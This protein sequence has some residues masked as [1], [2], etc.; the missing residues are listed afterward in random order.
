MAGASGFIGGAVVRELLAQ[1]WRVRGLYRDSDK[2]SAAIA[3]AGEGLEAC[4]GDGLR[5]GVADRLT[6]GAHA[7]VNCVG[8]LRESRPEATYRRVHV[9]LTEALIGASERAGVDQ[10]VQIS[11]LGVGPAATTEYGISKY[12]AEQIVR[13]SSIDWTILRPSL[14][15]GPDAE[16]MRMI[17]GWTLGRESPR[18]FL[19]YFCR[20]DVPKG[21][22]PRPPKPD[23]AL[24]APV[25]VGDVAR[26]VA[27]ALAH[28]AA[29]GEVYPLCGP[30]V[31]E[32]P[33]L[34][35][36]VRDAIP[37][38][39]KKPIVP[40]PG[41]LGHALAVGAGAV[42]M[43]GALPFGPSEP[44]MAM[45]DSICDTEKAQADLGFAPGPFADAVRGYAGAI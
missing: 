7:V 5:T 35:E 43:A 26:A 1:G 33:E 31:V 27:S 45:E 19:P 13:R 25:A 28:D 42:G 20:V 39:S 34:L 40:I 24:L 22:P 17:K 4:I 10:Y 2:A 36:T 14:V 9:E 38:G 11:A 30:E 18:F 29:R 8:I 15:H 44:L 12:A 6:E 23:S 41:H 16:L 3:E 21:F 37:M 32:W